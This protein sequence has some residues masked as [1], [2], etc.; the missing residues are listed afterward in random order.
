MSS[1]FRDRF[2]SMIASGEAKA[3]RLRAR[4]SQ[5]QVADVL[6]I[7]TSAVTR[8][9]AG[10]RIP[11]RY[12]ATEYLRLLSDLDA[13]HPVVAADDDG[14]AASLSEGMH[15]FSGVM[16]TEGTWTGDGR[17][18]S[19]GALGW[20]EP[21]EVNIP[22]QWQKE[23]SHGG[24]ND[25]TVN[26]G[27]ILKV[28]RDGDDVYGSGVLDAKSPDGAEAFRRMSTEPPTLSGVSIV[29]DDPDNGDV[30]LHYEGDQVV[31]IEFSS[32]RIR[33]LTLVDVP[34][35]VTGQI[36]LEVV[37]EDP[38]DDLS[39]AIR[40]ADE[41]HF[42][43]SNSTT[44][45]SWSGS[46]SRF[47]DEQYERSAAACDAGEGTVKERCFLPHHEPD[48]TLNL[49]GLSAAAGRADQTEHSPEAVARAK[50]HLR[51]HYRTQGLQV[52]EGIAATADELAYLSGEVLSMG[53][54][55]REGDD[56]LDQ[57]RTMV[58]AAHSIEIPERPPASWFEEPSGLPD[59]GGIQVTD[60]GRLFGLLAPRGVGHRSFRDR[61]VTVPMGNVDYSRWMSRTTIVDGGDRIATGAITMECG[62]AP[63]STGVRAS[64]AS[65]HY[66]NSC[67]VVA[68]ARIGENEHGVWVAGALMPDVSP[69]QVA[70]MLACQLSGDWRPHQEQRGVREFVAALLV[71]VPGFPVEASSA[72]IRITDGQLV[73]SAA[74]VQWYATGALLDDEP[75]EDSEGESIDGPESMDQDLPTWDEVLERKERAASVASLMAEIE[76]GD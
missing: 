50:A 2:A 14:E 12:L 58:A 56:G 41:G 1:S 42:G 28:W 64:D 7:S 74:P 54:S 22:L 16:V 36:A 45:A 10:E 55:G 32:G 37:E 20:P 71:P 49:N 3:I 53:G 6:G 61:R 18:F 63:T 67:S 35:F 38:D 21:A 65:D 13:D 60:D 70:R 30:E 69:A 26:V 47:T 52:P 17:M 8:W 9:E 76:K 4:W 23:T 48:G 29:A 39:L 33:A 31:G 62:H 19:E 43:S 40:I 24:I 75:T 34:A 44:D 46:T 66:E 72:S 5:R 57:L 25:V 59:I 11:N 15:P 68:T 51:S 27:R 73:A